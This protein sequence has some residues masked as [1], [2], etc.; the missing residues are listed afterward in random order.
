MIHFLHI[1]KDRNGPLFYF[2]AACLVL[3]VGFILATRF[4]TTQVYNVNAWYKPFKFALSIAIYSWTMAWFCYYLPHFNVGLFNG[5][6]ILLLGF[7]IIYI[8]L[9]AGR[10]Q[11]SHYNISTPLYGGLFFLMGLAASFVTL[12]TAYIGWLFFKNDFPELPMHY[13]WAIRLGIIIFVIFSFEGALMGSRLTHTIGGADGGEGIPLLNWSTKYGDPRIAH[14][15][16]MHALQVLPLLSFYLLKNTKATI[17]L[18]AI[19]LL[20]AV[21]TLV[22]ALQGKPFIKAKNQQQNEVLQ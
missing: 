12:Y 2:G 15:I 21:Y 20:L 19:Y 4:T 5:A 9:Q 16:G 22:Q 18:S 7:E 1:I 11:L 13:L 3:A 6:V 14:F 8:A 17:L 10:G